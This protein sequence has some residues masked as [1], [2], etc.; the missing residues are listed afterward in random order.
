MARP[1]RSSV[2]QCA[3]MNA[4]TWKLGAA[5]KNSAGSAAAWAARYADTA[6]ASSSGGTAV[7][8]RTPSPA[9]AALVKVAWLV[10]ATQSG[11]CGR[12]RG[13]GTSFRSGIS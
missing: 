13:L 11:G 4:A 3:V 6:G 10:A 9:R 12:W 8:P 2:S 1:R 5:P 7:N